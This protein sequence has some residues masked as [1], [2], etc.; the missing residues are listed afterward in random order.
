MFDAKLRPLIDQPLARLAIPLVRLGF[1]ANQIT[2]AGLAAGLAAAGAIALGHT[3]W[4]LALIAL[5]RLADGLDGAVARQTRQTDFGG[6]LDI[7]LDF[8]FYAAIPVGFGLLHP[9]NAVP[10]LVLLAGFVLSGTSFLAFAVL[11]AKRGIST[12]S[13]GKKSF[14]FVGG[15]TEGAE[16][17]AFFVLACLKPGWFWW[18]AYIF[19][20]LCVLTAV[21]RTLEARAVFRREPP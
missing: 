10:A 19:A 3:I 2:I 4:G 21:T 9:D 7:T 18:M 1:S 20:G 11:A 15:L 8:V 5:S 6:Y 17:I 12:D 16:T 13:R 14:Y